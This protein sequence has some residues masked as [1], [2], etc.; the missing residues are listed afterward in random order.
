MYKVESP[1][2]FG[3]CVCLF[4]FVVCLV[5]CV[6]VLSVLFPLQEIHVSLAKADHVR[7]IHSCKKTYGSKLHFFSLRASF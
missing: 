7:Q 2:G 4:G 5:G 1:F 6:L 3:S